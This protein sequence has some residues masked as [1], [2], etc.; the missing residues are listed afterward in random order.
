MRFIL[1]EFERIVKKPRHEEVRRTR[2]P[3]QFEKNKFTPTRMVIIAMV[4]Y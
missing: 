4:R 3:S 1:L 2:R